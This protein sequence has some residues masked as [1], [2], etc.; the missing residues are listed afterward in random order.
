MDDDDTLNDLRI[1]KSMQITIVPLFSESDVSDILKPSGK[2]S[3]LISH[4][5]SFVKTIDACRRR[6]PLGYHN[7]VAA[8]PTLPAPPTPIITTPDGCRPGLA[9]RDVFAPHLDAY[10]NN[11]VCDPSDIWNVFLEPQ[12]FDRRWKQ[13]VAFQVFFNFHAIL[14]CQIQALH[15]LWFIDHNLKGRIC[16]QV[17]MSYARLDP[18]KQGCI[19]FFFLAASTMYSGNQRFVSALHSVLTTFTL[20]SVNYDYTKARKQIT[21]YLCA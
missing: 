19:T 8:I 13:V 20:R 6:A 2:S 14:K 11:I 10:G 3:T 16:T 1:E 12:D 7:L 9:V 21:S 17:P 5:S 18:L 4:V 15:F